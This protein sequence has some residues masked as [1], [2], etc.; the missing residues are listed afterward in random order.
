MNS[1]SDEVANAAS[2]VSSSSQGLAAGSSLQASSLQKM[3]DAL[4]GMASMTRT[5]ADNA[6]LARSAATKASG[7]A[8]TGVD[9][10]LRMTQAIDRIK[11]SA[12]Q[13]ARIIKTIDEIA[14]QTNLLALNA[15][16]EAARA[17][18]AGKG[19]AVVA[20]EVRNLARRSAD[21]ARNTAE[22][23]EGAQK[24]AEAGVSVT[25]EVA[26]NLLSIQETVG[27]VAEL[28]TEIAKAAQEQAQ[29]IEQ[30]NA[31]AAEM[32]KVVQQNAATADKSS[33]SSEHLTAQAGDLSSL[34]RELLEM[35]GGRPDESADARPAAPAPAGLLASSAVGALPG[36]RGHVGMSKY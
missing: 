2:Q 3:T 31:S 1:G 16:V 30:V 25:A 34:V 8:Q 15:A 19:F 4:Q 13:T 12:V 7:M 26:N 27:K 29:G 11:A 21:A 9:A 18:E 6:G 17:G 14:F 33:S 5:T 32:D 35:V 22:L 23:I 24:N 10:M 20:E 28:I 36:S